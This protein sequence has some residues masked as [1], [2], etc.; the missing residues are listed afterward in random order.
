MDIQFGCSV[1]LF[2]WG[3][4]VQEEIVRQGVKIQRL[5]GMILNINEI[6]EQFYK[7]FRHRISVTDF[8]TWLYNT[9][10]IEEILGKQFYFSLLD[11]DYQ[12]KFARNQVEELV[13]PHIPFAYFEELHLKNLL[14]DT[15]RGN[16]NVV[17][18]LETFYNEYCDGYTFLRYLAFNYFP[19]MDGTDKKNW[20]SIVEKILPKLKAEA[21]RLLAFFE[22]GE[23]RI[24]G[25]HEY[26]DHRGYD[27]QI[28]VHSIE[29]MFEDGK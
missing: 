18:L 3:R 29:K 6:T 5:D 24:T 15:I 28:E 23:I 16:V 12:N 22:C 26:E 7:L 4:F 25:D 17:E 13:Y 19:F 21:Q 27:D 14:R 10:E 11:V 1:L 2:I 9:P 8:E 20:D